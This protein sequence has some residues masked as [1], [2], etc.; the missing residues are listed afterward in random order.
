[1]GFDE[2]LGQ[3]HAG[4]PALDPSAMQD[5]SPKSPIVENSTRVTSNKHTASGEAPAAT[6]ARSDAPAARNAMFA[7]NGIPSPSVG[8]TGF[9]NSYSSE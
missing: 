1:M 5:A 4:S 9:A 3:Q 8:S 6:D 2:A 7:P